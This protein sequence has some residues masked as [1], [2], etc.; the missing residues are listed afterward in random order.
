MLTTRE[1]TTLHGLM[2]RAEYHL[3]ALEGEKG[4]GE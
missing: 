1:V 4:D 2:R 3:G